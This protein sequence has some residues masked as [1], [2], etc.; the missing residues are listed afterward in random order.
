M[1]TILVI[2]DNPLVRDMVKEALVR[3]G[4]GVEVAA[5][6]REGLQLM[7]SCRVDLVVTDLVMPHKEGLETIQLL[8]QITQS[9]PILAISGTGKTGRADLLELA[10]SMGA[11]EVLAKP[12]QPAVLVA[13]V[14]AMLAGRAEVSSRPANPSGVNAGA[15]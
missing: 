7:A 12:F 3:A 1:A 2:D 11:T 9:L 4:Y 10:R 14:G 5:D 8:R 6:G 15:H 13:R